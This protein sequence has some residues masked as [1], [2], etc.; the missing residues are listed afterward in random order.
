M[1]KIILTKDSNIDVTYETVAKDETVYLATRW[2][3]PSERDLL[4][5]TALRLGEQAKYPLFADMTKKMTL[6]N[7]T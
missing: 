7:L 5:Q 1:V 3:M 6:D 2:I 4:E